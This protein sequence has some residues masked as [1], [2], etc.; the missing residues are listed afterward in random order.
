MKLIPHS[1]TA[2]QNSWSIM[3]LWQIGTALAA[4]IETVLYPFNVQIDKRCASTH[5]EEN[6]LAL[7]SI[8]ISPLSSAHPMIFQHHTVRTFTEFYLGC[9]LSKDR[10]LRFGSRRK[11][12][13]PYSDTLSLWLQDKY[14]LTMPPLLSR[15][16]FLQQARSQFSK[17]LLHIVSLWFHSLF[18]SPTG[19]LFTFP[20]RYFLRYRSLR[21]I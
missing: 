12:E 4:R 17:N 15:Q 16:L 10:S 5:F 8:G 2:Y 6:Q 1:L 18:H 20:S 14:L 13:T 3:S 11:D 19:V 21:S 7:S 9:I